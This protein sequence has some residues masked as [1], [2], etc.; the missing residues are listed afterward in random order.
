MRPALLSLLLLSV[1]P[2]CG[3][4]AE[5]EEGDRTAEKAKRSSFCRAGALG[6]LLT[7]SG[8]VGTSCSCITWSGPV[9]GKLVPQP[10][11]G[12]CST[13][14]GWCEM[15]TASPDYEAAAAGDPCWC[16]TLSATGSV[17]GRLLK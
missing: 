12:W 9:E 11:A 16:T 1:L 14:Q 5:S 7:S 2:A 17:K 3:V 13:S 6:C 15:D 10:A 8:S 4:D